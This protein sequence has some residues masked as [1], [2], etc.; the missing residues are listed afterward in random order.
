M[1]GPERLQKILAH[2]GLGSRRA[3]EEL[4][5]QG[6]VTVNGQ[7]AHLGLS[8]NPER[9]QIALDGK[10]LPAQEQPTYVLLHKP[11]GV[12]STARDPQGRPTVLDLVQ[13]PAR[14][15]PVGRL[16]Y[17][18]EGL[19]LL[20]DD[21][22]LAYRLTHPRYQVEREYHVLVQGRPDH[23]AMRRW[24]EGSVL[25]DERPA[26]AR[27]ELLRPEG[28]GTWLRV[29]IHEGRK[30]QVRLTAEALGH[31]VRRLVRVRLDG[32]KLGNLAAGEWRPLATEEVVRLRRAV[33]LRFS[34]TPAT[35]PSPLP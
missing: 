4:I 3:C 13:S 28:D 26:P 9:D 27:V 29:I 12:V 17:D 11:A 10:P 5:R 24:R 2:A 21:G 14:L 18:S 32:L 22:E 31:P 20:T 19:L 8:A 30:R 16:D 25:L 33:N 23:A 34:R 6:R 1:P 15:Y 35:R 7:V